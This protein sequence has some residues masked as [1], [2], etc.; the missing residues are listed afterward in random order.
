MAVETKTKAPL[1]LELDVGAAKS[2]LQLADPQELT[3]VREVDPE[4]D[5]LAE[6]LAEQL[7]SIDP[8]DLE[9]QD[10]H[11]G[12]VETAGRDLQRRSAHRSQMLEEPIRKLS[13]RGEE[14]GQVAKALVQLKLQVEQLDP[15]KFDFSPGWLSRALGSLPF[16]GTPMKRYFTQYES[17]QTVIDAI[18]HSLEEG[19]E[20]LKRDNITLGD[21]QREMRGLTHQ[22][23]KQIQLLVLL[24]R[25]LEARIENDLAGDEARRNFVSD[26][27]LYPLRQRITD[28]QQQ[29]IV[30]QQGVL[31]I[32][33]I[34]RN[35]HELVRGVNRAMDVTVSALQVA[36]TVA[37][38]LA[39]QRIVLDKIDAL[40]VTTSDL[41]SGTAERL[42]TQG[43]QI[44]RQATT[45]MLDLDA[46][47]SAF[48]D[49]TGAMDEIAR[50][51]QEALPAMSETIGELHTLTAQGEAA[52]QKLEEGRRTAP[53]L[54]LEPEGEPPA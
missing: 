48:S 41:L 53:L 10:Q 18:L 47:K 46:L 29:L 22:L 32:E 45:S 49:I 39:N 3:E 16:I 7:V 14:G 54:Q 31:A 52:I 17:A 51:R 12:A 13:A 25:K 50:F 8:A 4:L 19:R 28:L 43:A 35:N 38:A 36:V 26:E 9:V 44:H 27:L 5:A 34:V 42:R 1:A 6:R 21:D 20:Q 15:N 23:E 37:L 33:L 2:E 24:D 11:K 30:N 40:N